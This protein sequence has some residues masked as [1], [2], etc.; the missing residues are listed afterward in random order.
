MGPRLVNGKRAHAVGAVVPVS[1]AWNCYPER[2]T[3]PHHRVRE[4]KSGPSVPTRSSNGLSPQTDGHSLLPPG[5]PSLPATDR[6]PSGLVRD[7][8]A[9]LEVSWNAMH[10]SH[11]KTIPADPHR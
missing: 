2:S 1:R 4:R 6:R 5:L 8:A 10:L 11:P 7:P 3:P 9:Q